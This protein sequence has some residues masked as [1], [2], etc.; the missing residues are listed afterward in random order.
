MPTLVIGLLISKPMGVEFFALLLFAMFSIYG[1]GY[2]FAD[3]RPREIIIE[4]SF[5]LV[6]AAL[7]FLGL[8]VSPAW[9]AV[10]WF[11]HGT[12]DLLHHPATKVIQTE[13]PVWY[14]AGC[15]AYDWIIAAFILL[16]LI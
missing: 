9:L 6:G 13:V 4:M 7:S 2:A 15:A 16:W 12:W 11:A 10:G 3:G 1:W 5:F 8:W 14:A